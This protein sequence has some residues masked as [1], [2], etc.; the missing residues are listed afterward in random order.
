MTINVT[1]IS[2]GNDLKIEFTTIFKL[3]FYETN[4]NGLIARKLL[5]VFTYSLFLPITYSN[6]HVNIEN[7]TIMKSKILKGSLR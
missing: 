1:L 3:L 4:R 7:I 2:S 5:N 6:I